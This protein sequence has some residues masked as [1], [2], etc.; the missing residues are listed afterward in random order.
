MYF[1]EPQFAGIYVWKGKGYK[2]RR[3]YRDI[4]YIDFCGDSDE[5]VIG[6]IEEEGIGEIAPISIRLELYEYPKARKAPLLYYSPS[7][8][9][10]NKVRRSGTSF[11]EKNTNVAAYFVEKY[12]YEKFME[13]AEFLE[14]NDVN[15]LHCGNVGI[16]GEKIVFIDYGGYYSKDESENY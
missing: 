1:A 12:G 15:D 5:D 9:L 7:K 8:E 10:S 11:A 3:I 2:A 4:S 6:R 16:I 13:I 14:W